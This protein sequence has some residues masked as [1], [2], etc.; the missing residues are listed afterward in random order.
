VG[1]IKRARI[2]AR[3]WWRLVFARLGGFRA[4]LGCFYYEKKQKKKRPTL[5]AGAFLFLVLI[6]HSFNRL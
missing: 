1:K 3:N 2:G 6:N 4:L 5:S